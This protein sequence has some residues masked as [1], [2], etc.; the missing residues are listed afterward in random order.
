MITGDEATGDEGFLRPWTNRFLGFFGVVC[1][2]EL[3]RRC[4]ACVEY[5]SR[6]ERA[7]TSRPRIMD[8]RTG[9]CE[10]RA[11]LSLSEDIL[12]ISL[13]SLSSATSAAIA[14]S[15]LPL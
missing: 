7:R 1:G 9:F 3:G 8:G 10:L 5:L 12:N 11:W 2:E 13:T 15:K 14:S 6:N 4:G